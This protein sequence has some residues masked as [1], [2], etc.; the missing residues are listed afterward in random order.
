MA[1]V[2][3]KIETEQVVSVLI[4]CCFHLLL[5][6]QISAHSFARK[7]V[8]GSL[9]SLLHLPLSSFRC[10]WPVKRLVSSACAL[11]ESLLISL[12][13]PNVDISS[14]TA[15]SLVYNKSSLRLFDGI[16][17]FAECRICFAVCSSVDYL[18]C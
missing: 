10:V 12:Y 15:Y 4:K 1:V 3:L 14:D 7:G 2:D 11:E 8:I 5:Y 18:S 13:T 6:L 9:S 17:G 16:T